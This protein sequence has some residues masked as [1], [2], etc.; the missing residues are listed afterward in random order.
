MFWGAFLWSQSVSNQNTQHSVPLC[1]SQLVYS[2]CHLIG[3]QCR[4]GSLAK[5]SDLQARSNISMGCSSPSGVSAGVLWLLPYMIWGIGSSSPK[6]TWLMISLRFWAWLAHRSH[7]SLNPVHVLWSERV[8]N[9]TFCYAQWWSES[10][11]EKR[12]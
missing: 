8:P 6:Q 4:S 1:P 9:L 2:T 5:A 10:Q 12:S 11:Q 3:R 7:S